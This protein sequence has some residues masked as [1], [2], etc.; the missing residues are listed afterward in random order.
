MELKKYLQI[1][2]KWWWLI[3]ACVAVAGVAS[4]LGTRSTP[5][6]YSSRTTLM[7]GQAQQNPNPTQSDFYTAQALAQS[8]IDLARR[9]PVLQAA[10]D[11]LGLNWDW[12]V[13]QNMV[14]TRMVPG[15]Q[16]IEV[17]VLDTDPK[18]A[19]TL[20]AEI[21]HQLIQQSPAGTDPARDAQRE[22]IL[23]QIDDL[24]TNI[25]K[26]QAEIH[27]LD[28]VIAKANSA[29]VIQDARSRQA[30]LQAQV[31]T[32]QT[33][34]NQLLTNLQQGTTNFLSVVEPAQ[35]P[36]APVG[37]STLTNVL[38][39]A[40]IGATLAVGAAFVL[41]YLDDS[42][43]SADE[44]REIMG[45]P[46]LGTVAHIPG[47]TNESRLVASQPRS[48]IAES[49]RVLRTNL[50]FSTVDRHLCSVM[51][52]SASPDEGK[53]LMSANLAIVMAQAGKRVIL[54]DADMR[55]PSL[56]RIF[57]LTNGQG[58]STALLEGGEY[59]NATLQ[60]GPVEALQILP[61][62][63]LP[64]NPTELLGSRRMQDVMKL[65]CEQADFVILDSP[66]VL[67]VA[68]ASVLAAFVDGTL[69]VVDAGRTRRGRAERCHQALVA[70]GA[71]ILGVILNRYAG[72][73][74][75][76][77]YYGEDGTRR[78][79]TTFDRFAPQLRRLYQRSVRMLARQPKPPQPVEA[80]GKPEHS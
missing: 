3:A 7:V 63:P 77:Y 21:A 60:K 71:N 27:Q 17:A 4:Y 46:T 29:R 61:A 67:A 64:P 48:P 80:E 31:S 11:T 12:V 70:V 41:N 74:E 26:S 45:L 65:L 32:W 35:L 5:R 62:G 79:Q 14:T 19:Q 6:T 15:T 69:L 39:A 56:H 22:F 25:Q 54:I 78:I 37:P 1:L 40:V 42:I 34:Y 36:T 55:R 49:Y 28:D 18:R 20:A 44:V 23:T 68:D 30:A 59:V 51:I 52:S 47:E 76:Y 38:L 72:H 2:V 57:G 53:S 9:E 66:P 16:L 50:Q 58:L 73:K 8:Y 33:T 24:K 10:L 43:H 13:L 75:S